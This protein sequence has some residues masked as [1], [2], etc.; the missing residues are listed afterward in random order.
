MV[1]TTVSHLGKVLRDELPTPFHRMWRW[2]ENVRP[3]VGTCF[4]GMQQG[5]FCRSVEG[6]CRFPGGEEIAFALCHR[7]RLCDLPGGL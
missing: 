3:D 6:Q 1:M 4:A 5:F 2:G 7:L